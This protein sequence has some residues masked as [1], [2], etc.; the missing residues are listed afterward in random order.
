M[1][2]EVNET[3]N[4][5][6]KWTVISGPVEGDFQGAFWLCRCDCGTEKAISGSRLRLGRSRQCVP[7]QRIARKTHGMAGKTPEYQ[8]WVHLIMRCENKKD[9]AYNR[10]GGRGIKVC[11][12][13][14]DSFTN[15]L[16]DMGPRPSTKHS[17]DRINNDGNYEPGNCRWATRAEQNAN[18]SQNR[19]F[20]IGNET[21]CLA[22]WAAR[23]GIS[24][25]SLWARLNLGWDIQM[26]L[27]APKNTKRRID[28]KMKAG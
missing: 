20:T 22:H 14:R 16:A 21:L 1:P 7:C 24:K 2:N 25:A 3:G 11:E 6:G 19:L 8:T 9:R 4:R 27:T 17:I 26:A 12:S 5:Y 10:Y 23:F 13:W 28:G 18:T 15:F